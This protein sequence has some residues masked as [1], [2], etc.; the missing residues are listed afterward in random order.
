[1]LDRERD[2]KLLVQATGYKEDVNNKGRPVLYAATISIPPDFKEAPKIPPTI[3]TE[4]ASVG[5]PGHADR[6]CN[7]SATEKIKAVC[8]GTV[9]C[10]FQADPIYLCNGQDIAPN[11]RKTFGASLK[12]GPS[13]RLV[14][15][16]K[17]YHFQC[18]AKGFQ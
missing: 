16:F 8:D 14:V 18:G 3:L 9:E 4:W 11:E 1:M 2:K 6:N 12:C 7:Q 10:T 17:E 5:A 15:D 13:G